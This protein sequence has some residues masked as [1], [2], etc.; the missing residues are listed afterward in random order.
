MLPRKRRLNRKSIKKVL[1][2]S[3]FF[4]NHNFSLRYLVSPAELSKFA[5]VVPSIAAKKAVIRNKIKRRA[6]AAVFK[7]LPFLKEGYL[8]AL[9]FKK[10]SEQ[11]SFKELETEISKNFKKINIFK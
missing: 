8:V 5:F 7:L 1:K 9:F 4:F 2:E 6:R 3:R 10:G 11:L